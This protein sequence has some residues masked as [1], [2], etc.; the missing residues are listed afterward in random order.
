MIFILYVPS[1]LSNAA[2]SYRCCLVASALCAVAVSSLLASAPLLFRCFWPLRCCCLVA[3]GLCAAAVSSLLTSSSS[4][5]LDAGLAP[6]RTVQP[7]PALPCVVGMLNCTFGGSKMRRRGRKRGGGGSPRWGGRRVEGGSLATSSGICEKGI[8]IF[9]C[10]RVDHVDSPT[11]HT[12]HISQRFNFQVQCEG[13]YLMASSPP[14]CSLFC[15]RY[16]TSLK[17]H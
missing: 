15:W 10:A 8:F 16:G 2:K 14:G 5:H 17:R 11:T 12:Y 1:D 9:F 7:S 4:V 3:F 6:F 13:I